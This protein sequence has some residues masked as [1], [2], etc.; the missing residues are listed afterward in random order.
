V[1]EF[2]NPIEIRPLLFHERERG[3]LEHFHGLDVNVAVSD[4]SR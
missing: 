3:W 2:D 4:H 1:A